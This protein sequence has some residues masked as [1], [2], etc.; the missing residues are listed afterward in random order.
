MSGFAARGVGFS[1]FCRR[2]P[3]GRAHGSTLSPQGNR[4]QSMTGSRLLPP[5]RVNS[6]SVQQ[7][8]YAF[9]APSLVLFPHIPDV[10]STLLRPTLFSS[11]PGEPYNFGDEG[12]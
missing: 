6:S 11:A 3:L 8:M 5:F 7:Y 9:T 12:Q 2:H 10:P 1:R 4:P